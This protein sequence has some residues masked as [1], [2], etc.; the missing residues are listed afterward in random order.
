MG[1]RFSN[2]RLRLRNGVLAM[3]ASIPAAPA[4]P[5]PSADGTV[6]VA[7]ERQA[8]WIY[9]RVGVS[10]AVAVSG[11]CTA[12]AGTTIEARAVDET[13][14]I[15]IGNWAVVGTV[16]ADG[17]Y[18]GTFVAPQGKWYRRQ[19]R[20][21]NSSTAIATETNSFGVGIGI[22]ELGQSNMANFKTSGNFYP[23]GDPNAYEYS[24][25]GVL[26]RLGNISKKN[27]SG[28]D[29]YPPNTLIRNAT[30]TPTGYTDYLNSTAGGGTNSDG[31]VYVANLVAETTGLPV[32]VI[33]LAV[34]GTS[35][36]TYWKTGQKG[37]TD[38]SAAL[39]SIGGD[40][41]IAIWLQGENNAI[42]MSGATYQGHLADIQAQFHTLTGRNATNFKF[43]VI[44]LGPTSTGVTGNLG[45]A[46]TD[47]QSFGKMRIAQRDWAY[48]TPGAFYVGGVHDM[49]L[50]SAADNI[51]I[52]GEGFNTLGRRYAKS[53]NA[54]LGFGTTSAGPKM[55]SASRSGNIVTVNVQHTGGTALQ[56]GAGGT[57]TALGGFIFKDGAG[58]EV[59]ITATQITSPT[60]V[61]LTLA[62]APTGACTLS[63]AMQNSPYTVDPNNVKSGFSA[64]AVLRDNALYYS[65]IIKNND[66]PLGSPMQPC[67]AITVTGG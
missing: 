51:H 67:A 19:V 31:Y 14:G 21:A 20:I 44:S 65:A 15:A 53:I 17:T 62:S 57:G 29:V 23:L 24:A 8:R 1:A 47:P 25:A 52:T 43:G 60:T 3:I 18:A 34:G 59:A 48:S 55:V 7:A 11:T 2:G 9:Q 64:A 45:Y 58:G 12:P 22:A 13:T 35:I 61:Q 30:F 4:D 40:C 41:E 32:F 38:F 56:D 36:E 39:N 27:A 37:W 33:N 46:G 16:A 50:T 63:Y 28:A 42:A 26:R 54:A 49:D 10:K 5:G 6:T 66:N